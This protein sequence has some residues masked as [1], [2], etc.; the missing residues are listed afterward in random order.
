[1]KKILVAILLIG[2]GFQAFAKDTVVVL[3][4]NVG[5]I[6]LK[7]YPE[8]APLAVENFT[9][10]VKNGY[11]NG[12]IFHRIIKGFMIQGGDPTATG[13]GSPGYKF[14]DEFDP[15]LKHDKPG[16][17][18]MANSGPNTNGSQFF[19]THSPQPHL[20]GRYTIFGQVVE[21]L[22]NLFGGG[23]QGAVRGDVGKHLQERLVTLSG[24][25]VAVLVVGQLLDR[26]AGAA[27]GAR[28]QPTAQKDQRDNDRC[29]FE[30]NG[31]GIGRQKPRRKQCNG[32]KYPSRRG[33]Q[34]H[35]R[36]HIRR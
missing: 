9:T 5:K 28:F 24:F 14:D 10:H 7:M 26:L 12:L 21:G 34:H 17:L 6:E 32:R 25:G 20:D 1:M 23:V 3:E 30:I 29:G 33:A 13:S 8:V 22:L 35:E 15:T 18:S 36:I 31:A 27:F 19:I 4:T 2:L 11:Y 16:I